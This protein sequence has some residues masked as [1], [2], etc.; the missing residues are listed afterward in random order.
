[1]RARMA[2]ATANVLYERVEVSL[3]AKPEALL[4]VSPKGTVPVLVLDDGQVLDQ[5]LDIMHWAL[6]PERDGGLNDV[7]RGLIDANDGPFKWHLDR[8]KYPQRYGLSE[9]VGLEHRAHALTYLQELDIALT[10]TPE[11][12]GS[13]Q[14]PSFLAMAVFPFVR[15]FAKHD[16]TKSQGLELPALLGWRRDF[17][18]NPLFTAIMKP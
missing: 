4:R 3:K 11:L 13:T 8:Y 18:S 12:F 6:K 15:Q 10:K 7:I 16:E 5:S 2:L 9:A 17:E 14:E 1:M